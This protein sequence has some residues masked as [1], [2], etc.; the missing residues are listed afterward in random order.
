MDD[1]GLESG[2][3]NSF[4]ERY[5]EYNDGQIKEILKN[6]K[7]YQEAAVLAAV[8]I[9]I[10]RGLIHSEQDLM[11]PEYQTK[12]AAGL[13]VFPVITSYYQYQKVTASIFRI[14]YLLAL[15][16]IVFGLFKYSEGQSELSIAGFVAGTVWAL[17][18][19]L[20]QKT[21]H[22]AIA[23]VMTLFVVLLSVVAGS[24][25]FSKEKIVFLDLFMLAIVAIL[26][27]YFIFY[28]KNLHNSKP[29]QI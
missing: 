10:E 26:P 2:L 12:S 16:P 28:L 14:L 4:Y 17:L 29:D 5:S 7:N 1:I 9:A 8:K 19:Y 24:W 15:I 22:G 18:T 23:W 21:K 3:Q 6:H 20:L 25:I 13:S 11:A 27:V